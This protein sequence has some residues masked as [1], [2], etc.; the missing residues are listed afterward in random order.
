VL[1][2]YRKG[3]QIYLKTERIKRQEYRLKNTSNYFWRTHAKQEIDWVEEN[4]GTLNAFEFKWSKSS[5]SK[6]PTAWKK[7]YPAA[8]FE[9]VNR[10]NYLNF[11]T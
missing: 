10:T 5:N 8:S 3:H 11:I 4:E 6:I 1:I 7:G 2:E 9:V